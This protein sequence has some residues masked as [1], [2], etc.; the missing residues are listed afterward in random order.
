MRNKNLKIFNDYLQYLLRKE[1][2]VYV[3][4]IEKSIMTGK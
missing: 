1:M 4:K 2:L 3:K